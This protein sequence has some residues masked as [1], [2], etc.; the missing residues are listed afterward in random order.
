MHFQAL[1]SMGILRGDPRIKPVIDALE[2]IKKKNP[3]KI[4][5]INNINLDFNE[6]TK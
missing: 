4:Y 6:F 1:E 2:N 5:S 3:R